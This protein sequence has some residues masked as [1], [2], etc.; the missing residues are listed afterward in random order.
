MKFKILTL[1]LS[2]G[3]VLAACGN[4]SDDNMDKKEDNQQTTQSSNDKM[5]KDSNDTND[6]D[7]MDDQ[8]DRDDQKT[9]KMNDKTVQLKDIQTEP[10][11][12][13]KTA[14]KAFDGKMK[15]IEYKQDNGEWIYKI[16]LVNGNKEAEV[17]VSDKDNKAIKTEEETES[18][19]QDNKTIDYK[20]MIS[21]DEAVKTAQKETKGDLKQWKLNEDDGQLVYEVKIAD[22]NDDREYLIDAKSGKLIGEDR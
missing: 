15:K 20:E 13:I 7:D 10:E 14:Q 8:N 11:E 4:D 6:Q 19:N 22:Q 1:L 12:A 18:D 2:A 17:K 3:I 16:D 5:D 9:D 21:Y